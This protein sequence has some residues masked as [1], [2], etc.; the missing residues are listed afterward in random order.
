VNA[1]AAAVLD[2]WFGPPPPMSR[3][4]W[5]RKDPAFDA[6]I[7]A[8]FGT[9][10][11]QAIDQGLDWGDDAAAGLAQ[12][13]VLDQFPRNLF[14]GQARAFAGDAQA[15]RLAL[16]LIDRG[17]HLALHPL[18]RW[19]LYLPLEHAEDPALQDRC[20]ELVGALAAA[21]PAHGGALDYAERHRD[22]IRRFGRF[23]HRNAAL[24]RASTAEELAYL[25]TPGSGF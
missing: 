23:P 16:D 21:D 14:R 19:F 1:D 3:A 17:A 11:E 9:L 8:R 4:E 20:V 7:R 15:R 18:Q 25:A 22:V 10:V 6:A 13:V 24:G 5:F 2:F 12:V